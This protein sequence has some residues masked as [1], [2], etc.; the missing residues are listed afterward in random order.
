MARFQAFRIHETDGGVRTGFEELSLD[1]LTAGEVVVRVRYSSINFKDALAATGKGKILRRSPLVGG[2]DLAG[3]VE[4]SEDPGFAPGDRVLVCGG[5][6][7]ETLDGGYAERAR[8][9]ARVVVRTPAGLSDFEAMAIGTAGLTAAM[10]VDRMERNGQTPEHGPVAVTGATGGVGSVAIDLL[11][12]RGYAVTAVT[13]KSTHDEYLR[14]LGASEILR[15]QEIEYGTRPLEKALWGG[16]VDS[17]GG[18]LLAWLTRTC[19]PLGNIASIGLA[20]GHKLETTVMPFIL[21]GVSL[22]GINSVEPPAEVRDHVWAR[23]AGDMKPRHLDRIVSRTVPFAELPDAFE[24]FMRGE[25]TG[26]LV[27]GIGGAE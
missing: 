17:V 3:T 1:D 24:P 18:D 9:P 27:I 5:G 15:R 4:S 12:A 13:G 23:L 14:E 11:S 6:L 26:R 25:V 10:A 8:V 19:K 7:S 16:A 2:I 21:R 20:G 22:L